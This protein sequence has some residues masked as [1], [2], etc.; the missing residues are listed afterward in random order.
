MPKRFA[1]KNIQ[2]QRF[3]VVMIEFIQQKRSFNCEHGSVIRFANNNEESN[4]TFLNF[5]KS[6]NKKIN[7]LYLV[8]EKSSI[9]RISN[10]LN[11]RN[12]SLADLLKIVNPQSTTI[13][14]RK[15]F[16]RRLKVMF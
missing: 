12:M 10:I 2:I 8:N 9:M 11:S 6:I 7:C 1:F 15:E 14:D 4:K 13:I 3:I 5:P 16:I